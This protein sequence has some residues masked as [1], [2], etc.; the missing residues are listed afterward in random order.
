MRIIKKSYILLFIFTFYGCAKQS[1]PTGGPRDKKPPILIESQ[2]RNQAL[3]SRPTDIKLTFDEFISLE[4]ASKSIVITPR[5]DKDK[6]EITALKNTVNIKLNQD[7][8]DNTTYAFDFQKAVVDLS[9]KNPAENLKIVFSTGSEID[10]LTLSG[11]VNLY[12][13]DRKE[14]N[15]NVLV[16]LYPK[17]DTTDIFTGQPYYLGQLDTAG[18]FKISNIKN[19]EYR[20]FAWKDNNG[21][22]KA[23]YKTEEYDFFPDIINLTQGKENLIFN[24]SKAD[25]TPIRILRSATFGRNYDI[26]LNKDP[27]RTTVKSEYLNDGYFYTNT[28]DKR[29]RLYSQTTRQ[30]SIPFNIQVMDSVGYEKDTTIW[31]KFKESDRKPEKLE[32]TVN[33]GKSFYEELEIEFQFNKPI[34]KVNFDS[35]YIE[36]D[37]AKRIPIIEEMLSFRD[38][39]KRDVI[40][41]KTVIKEKIEKDI[42]TLKAKDSTF[43]DI[44]GQINEKEIKANYRKL[45]K[46]ELADEIKG[47]IEGAEP[48]FIVQLI[49]NKNEI[50]KE[51]FIPTGNTYSFKMIEPGTFK[52]RVIEDKNNNQIWDPSNYNLKK[53]AERIFYYIGEENKNEIIVRSGW[54]LEDQNIKASPRTGFNENEKRDVENLKSRVNNL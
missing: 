23:E 4:N 32:T 1:S 9:E 13:N 5:I 27:V 39:A 46:E 34:L 51:I 8:E 6:I 43:T 29:I 50:I 33:S 20:A 37:S 14:D 45:T 47:K 52:L 12:F 3:N 24:L 10:S 11:K 15:K 48:P 18:N 17:N 36:Y 7:L 28:K 35:L 49:D 25:L 40:K 38:S 30:D 19:G 16:G 42:I 41:I 2:P 31:A 53:L 44:E 54:T 21:N 26:I 22:I